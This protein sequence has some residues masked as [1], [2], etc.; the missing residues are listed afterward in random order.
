MLVSIVSALFGVKATGCGSG[1]AGLM[2]TTDRYGNKGGCAPG[3][4]QEE[5]RSRIK[6]S[7]GAVGEGLRREA[8]DQRRGE[9]PRC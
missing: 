8:Y 1:E 5:L 2:F 4:L 9:L 6:R 3:G 7:R